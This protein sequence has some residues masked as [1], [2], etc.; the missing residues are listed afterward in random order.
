MQIAPR[1]ATKRNEAVNR[2]AAV[3]LRQTGLPSGSATPMGRIIHDK[4]IER[5]P[6]H[7]EP[8]RYLVRVVDQ[9]FTE[10]SQKGTLGFSLRFLVIRN[11]DQPNAPCKEYLREIIWWISDKT[12]DRTMHDLRTLGYRGSTLAGVDPDTC[13][14]HDFRNQEI[15]LVCEH[16][17]DPKNC[18]QERWSFRTSRARLKDKSK[19]RFFDR[20]LAPRQG[21]A[22]GDSIGSDQGI[23]DEDVPF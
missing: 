3:I 16:E 1:T 13:D 5:M 18:M 14:F 7:F 23:T 9:C 17:P 12:L 8:G 22:E 2:R 4:E 15:E 19:I 6:T 21:P 10:S 20:M 11:S